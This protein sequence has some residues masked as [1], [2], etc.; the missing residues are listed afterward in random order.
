MRPFVNSLFAENISEFR[1]SIAKLFHYICHKCHLL[2]GYNN[3]LESN[4]SDVHDVKDIILCP[5]YVGKH[6]VGLYFFIKLLAWLS[7]RNF[8]RKYWKPW[9]GTHWARF[10]NIAAYTSYIGIFI[11]T[12]KQHLNNFGIWSMGVSMMALFQCRR[13]KK[14]RNG[15]QKCSRIGNNSNNVNIC[16]KWIGRE[17]VMFGEEPAYNRWENCWT[18]RQIKRGEQS[19]ISSNVKCA[20]RL[21]ASRTENVQAQTTGIAWRALEPHPRP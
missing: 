18:L 10:N 9:S 19:S 7:E 5:S 4:L 11:A 2:L 8:P 6:K 15:Y 21:L 13:P 1:V 20:G 12:T 16:S 3:G 14:T 17:K